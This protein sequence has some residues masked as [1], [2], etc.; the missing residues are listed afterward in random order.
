VLNGLG[1]IGQIAVSCSLNRVLKRHY[2]EF[3]YQE[4]KLIFTMIVILIAALICK[5][6]L[7]VFRLYMGDTYESFFQKSEQ[8]NDWVSPG[9]WLINFIVGEFLP[10]SALL[11]SF[12]YGLTRRNKVIRSRKYSA[13]NKKCNKASVVID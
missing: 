6:G 9:F 11:M 7:G 3:Y 13:N 10:I 1:L 2:P 12:W 5:I 4:R 8:N